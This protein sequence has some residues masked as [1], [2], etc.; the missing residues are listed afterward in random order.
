MRRSL[1]M[2]AV[3]VCLVSGTAHAQS[4][5]F[6]LGLIIGEPTGLSA[7]LWQSRTTALDFAAAWSFADEAAFH[8]HG[9]FLVHKFNLI[10]VERGQLPV[11]YGIG[12]RVKLSDEKKHDDTSLGLRIP[13]GLDYLFAGGT[14]LDVFLEL[15][16][17][18]DL[19]PNTDVTLNASLGMRYWFH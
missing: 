16:P 17:I 14:P 10:R 13:V 5:G 11:Y 4:R 6:G 3:L 2:I 9:D 12:L 8:L 19:V 15:V 7:K 1:G 18:L